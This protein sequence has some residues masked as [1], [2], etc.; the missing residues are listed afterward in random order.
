[1]LFLLASHS[2]ILYEKLE[3]KSVLSVRGQEGY[4]DGGHRAGDQCWFVPDEMTSQRLSALLFFWNTEDPIEN[5]LLCL[6]S[7]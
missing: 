3:R 2:L 4:G 5:A 6:F 1:M 7:F